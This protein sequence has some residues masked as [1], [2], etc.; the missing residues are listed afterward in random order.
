MRTD[1]LRLVSALCQADVH[2]KVFLVPLATLTKQ[3]LFGTSGVVMV[4]AYLQPV[5]AL[6]QAV[7]EWELLLAAAV[8]CVW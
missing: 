3:E 4:L 8:E 5:S 7:P 1:A 2:N 6:I